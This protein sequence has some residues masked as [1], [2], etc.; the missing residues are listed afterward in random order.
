MQ[1]LYK[2]LWLIFICCMY[3][4]SKAAARYVHN[5]L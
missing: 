2:I 1:F 3:V 5:S 4:E